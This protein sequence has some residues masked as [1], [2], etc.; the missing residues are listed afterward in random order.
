LP[1]GIAINVQQLRLLTG[2]SKSSINGS[3]QK[4]G[5]RVNLSSV[6]PAFLKDH[7]VEFR[8][9]TVRTR[10]DSADRLLSPPSFLAF[11]G[12]PPAKFEV[13]LEGIGKPWTMPMD[14]G[15]E[16]LFQDPFY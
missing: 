14:Q 3:L 12:K 5:Y 10:D 8:K 2:R 11:T 15:L 16:W 6:L 4:I 13:C 1:D 7:S 9:W